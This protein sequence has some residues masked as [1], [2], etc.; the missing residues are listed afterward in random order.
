MNTKLVMPVGKLHRQNMTCWVTKIPEYDK[1]LHLWRFLVVPSL[2]TE[3]IRLR[4]VMGL[5]K[6]YDH[7]RQIL[8]GGNFIF[9]YGSPEQPIRVKVSSFEDM[10][11]ELR[12]DDNEQN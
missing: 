2:T 7:E 1:E 11:N 5:P 9:E 8:V 12:G 10:A 6:I 4:L 3:T